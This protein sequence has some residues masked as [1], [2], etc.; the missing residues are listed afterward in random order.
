[1]E[2]APMFLSA[3]CDARQLPVVDRLRGLE[4]QS[5]I[6]I[7]VPEDLL[8]RLDRLDFRLQSTT[9]TNQPTIDA[10]NTLRVDVNRLHEHQSSLYNRPTNLPDTTAYTSQPRTS[11]ET[12]RHPLFEPKLV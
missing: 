4:A 10:P 1:M 12:L 5:S 2:N 11:I 7:E 6:Q 9:M 3:E 8:A